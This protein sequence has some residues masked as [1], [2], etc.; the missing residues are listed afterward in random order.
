MTGKAIG[1]SF[2]IGYAGTPSREGKNAPEIVN[3]PVKSDSTTI[4]FG[5]PV[6]LNTDNT[7]SSVK[8][9]TLTAANFLGIAVAETKTNLTFPLPYGTAETSGSYLAGEPID[10]MQTGTICVQV[11]GTPTAGGA[12]YVR[13]ALATAFPDEEIGQIRTAADGGN[14]VQLT[15]CSFKTNRVD[16][17]GITELF[18]RFPVN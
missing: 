16:A 17:N 7:V 2:N 3:L 13:T 14:T 4:L 8:D 10:V 15:N 6:V 1:L 9:V 11:V 18:V 5:E 12:V